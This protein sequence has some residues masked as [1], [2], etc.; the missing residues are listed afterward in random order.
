MRSKVGAWA[1]FLACLLLLTFAATTHYS[2]IADLAFISLRLSLLAVLSILV[3][4]ERWRHRDDWRQQG[5]YPRSDAGDTI[6]QR[7]RRWY[8][9]EQTRPS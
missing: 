5:T 8:Y 1:V 7:F 3:V 2:K 9:G 6:L 4:R